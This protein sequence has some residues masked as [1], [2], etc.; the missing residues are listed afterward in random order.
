MLKWTVK[1]YI[2]GKCCAMHLTYLFIVLE[3]IS[4][5]EVSIFVKN[6]S[7]CK[8]NWIWKRFEVH[9]IPKLN[10]KTWK[11]QTMWL[12]VIKPNHKRVLLSICYLTN[13]FSGNNSSLTA[14]SPDYGFASSPPGVREAA[15]SLVTC[16]QITPSPPP[17]E[18]AVARVLWSWLQ[19]VSNS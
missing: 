7:G 11:K 8:F 19:Q 9:L 16:L 3:L 6:C 5:W 13:S 17:P 18:P 14:H 2:I 12:I 4:F 10:S 1:K 15:N